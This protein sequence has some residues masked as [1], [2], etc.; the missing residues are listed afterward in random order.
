MQQL[1]SI[2]LGVLTALGI[3][4]AVF[5][6]GKSSS[7]R[8][9]KEKQLDSLKESIEIKSHVQ[10]GVS[11]SSDSNVDSELLSKWVRK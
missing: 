9:A 3:L 8:K 4:V 2:F 1:K 5:L 10:K 11:S 6:K 7:V